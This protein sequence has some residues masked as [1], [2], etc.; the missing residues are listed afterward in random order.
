M[1]STHTNINM[2]NLDYM[3]HISYPKFKNH[4]DEKTLKWIEKQIENHE[5]KNF[6]ATEKLH[7]SNFSIY[8]NGKTIKCARRNGFLE[9]NENFHQAQNIAEKVK[10]KIFALY[11]YVR[12]NVDYTFETEEDFVLILFGEVTGERVQ[13]GISYGENAVRFFDILIYKE[14]AMKF[15]DYSEFK[16]VCD[17]FEL[18]TV[19]VLAEGSLEELLKMNPEFDSKILGTDNNTAE[20]MVLKFWHEKEFLAGEDRDRIMLKFKCKKFDE[21]QNAPKVKNNAVMDDADMEFLS[22]EF[23][24]CL[25]FSRLQAVKSK[26]NSKQAKN[27]QVMTEKMYEDVLDDM[28]EESK[29][30]LVTNEVLVKKGTS[31]VSKFV[32][33]NIKILNFSNEE[34]KVYQ[35]KIEMI[36]QFGM[37][38]FEKYH[39]GDVNVGSLRTAILKF[40][41]LDSISKNVTNALM[42]AVLQKAKEF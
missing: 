18:E 9:E 33:D 25:T 36:Q 1:G 39:G 32:A 11:K 38:D 23:G 26:L 16:M 17:K 2:N 8:T 41:N 27:R 14:S 20:G 37:A 29:E 15:M 13:L 40:L 7:G 35:G 10:D 24:I 4:Y 28:A 19:P 42:P 30:K 3:R 5:N 6:I 31:M 12:E 22:N 34:Y 21:I